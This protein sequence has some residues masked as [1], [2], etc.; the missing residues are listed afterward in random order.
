VVFAQEVDGDPLQ[1]LWDAIAEL[2]DTIHNMRQGV[3]TLRNEFNADV[4]H[5]AQFELDV[6]Q[7]ITHLLFFD[8]TLFD[9]LT[10]TNVAVQENTDSINVH[11]Q[12]INDLNQTAAGLQTQIDTTNVQVITNQ[13]VTEQKINDL[14]Q[15]DQGLQ[16]QINNFSS[17]IDRGKLYE[18]INSN[19]NENTAYC[20][21]NNDILLFGYCA[22][23][24]MGEAPLS[25]LVFYDAFV[26]Y[27]YSNNP[28][29]TMLAGPFVVGG[30]T[31][32]P[33]AC[34]ASSPSLFLS[35]G[36]SFETQMYANQ[37]G[38]ELFI[39]VTDKPGFLG[40]SAENGYFIRVF[41]NSGGSTIT[42]YRLDTG[43]AYAL[44]S[45]QGISVPIQ[46]DF[47]IKAERDSGGLWQMQL[48]GNPIG[49][50]VVD[51]TYSNFTNVHLRFDGFQNLDAGTFDKIKI[52]SADANFGLN[53]FVN[54]NDVNSPLGIRCQYNGRAR[55][56]CLSQN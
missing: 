22:G 28:T 45:F 52:T 50:P 47:T 9:A 2:R 36:F 56:L 5:L 49:N 38:D 4:Q 21:D 42:L 18:V 33:S 51:S 32:G 17:Q 37:S 43:T 3:G 35:G 48:D 40:Q 30:P 46:T 25:S 8:N 6:N 31:G 13:I 34:E 44:T 55:A 20:N 23:T 27:E 53:G 1:P 24:F 41:A 16:N 7:E 14:N 54:V 19:P 15:T 29:W 11:S 10:A 39:G 26:D 12:E